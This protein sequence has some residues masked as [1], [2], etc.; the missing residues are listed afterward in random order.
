M[1]HDF[2]NTL[3]TFYLIFLFAY[4][5]WCDTF[6]VKVPGIN[7]M[8]LQC[9][10]VKTEF[11]DTWRKHFISFTLEYWCKKDMHTM[12]TWYTITLYNMN[13][14]FASANTPNHEVS[15]D[16]LHT[17]ETVNCSKPRWPFLSSHLLQHFGNR[18]VAR[19]KRFLISHNALRDQ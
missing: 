13:I 9:L 10:K 18:P 19:L 14:S 17:T 15:S 8:D 3:W 12:W 5:Q 4:M 1:I 2:Q 6:H 16:T 11:G 7:L